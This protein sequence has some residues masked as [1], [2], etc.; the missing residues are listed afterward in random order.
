VPL[1][2]EQLLF[3]MGTS[4]TPRTRSA[5]RRI[6]DLGGTATYDEVILQRW[7]SFSATY[8]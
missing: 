8:S 3:R 7:S 5:P 1:R 2:E 6:T 4:L